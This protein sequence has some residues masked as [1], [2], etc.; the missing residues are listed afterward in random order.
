M[1]LKLQNDRAAAIA[2]LSD[3]QLRFH[4]IYEAIRFDTR[5]GATR[6]QLATGNML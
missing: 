1:F 4:P 2:D 3:V 5:G 6:Q